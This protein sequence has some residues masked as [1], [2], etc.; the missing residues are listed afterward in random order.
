MTQG[1]W[2]HPYPEK[3][4]WL[5]TKTDDG[6]FAVYTCKEGD[7]YQKVEGTVTKDTTE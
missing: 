1:G 2:P 7:A 5:L 4:R 6:W 3:P